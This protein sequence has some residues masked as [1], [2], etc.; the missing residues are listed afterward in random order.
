MV[1]G[2]SGGLSGLPGSYRNHVK[3]GKKTGADQEAI[4]ASIRGYFEKDAPDPE[5]WKVV[6][7]YRRGPY[8]YHLLQ[9]PANPEETLE[10]STNEGGPD[11]Q[12]KFR[13]KILRFND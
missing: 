5:G 13:R 3:G 9:N 2:I 1:K 10:V 12:G 4:E 8:Q 6:E 7:T 11:E